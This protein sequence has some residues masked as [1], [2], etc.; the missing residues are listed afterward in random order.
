MIFSTENNKGILLWKL[1]LEGKKTIT[2]RPITQKYKVGQILKVQPKRG[3]KAICVCGKEYKEHLFEGEDDYVPCKKYIPARISITSLMP[4][5]DWIATLSI[6]MLV[7][8]GMD[9]KQSAKLMEGEFER[10]AHREGFSSRQDLQNA[11]KK[12]YKG[13]VVELNRIEF[14]LERK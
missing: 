3:Q 5:N 6:N 8:T 10:E 4:E 7:K 13:K 2:R 14:I 12:I 9:E 1:V 11:L